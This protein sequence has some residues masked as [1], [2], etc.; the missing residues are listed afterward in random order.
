MAA[1]VPYK[2]GPKLPIHA[3]W[4]VFWKDCL[5]DDVLAREILSKERFAERIA[6]VIL[7]RSSGKTDFVELPA[8]RQ[9]QVLKQL[10]SMPR[11]ALLD[12]LG[13]LWLAP[14]VAPELPN[15]EVRERLGIRS[16]DDIKLALRYRDQNPAHV[17]GPLT[18]QTSLASQGTLCLL[19]WFTL[20]ESPLRNRLKLLFPKRAG[21]IDASGERV[22]LVSRFMG[23]AEAREGLGQ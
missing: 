7:Q 9:G 5:P 23:D 18:E 2:S 1:V 10:L 3:D 15:A 17:V 11:E 12:K 4:L 16:R 13:L 20:F 19:A 6:H 14:V 8:T 21:A 22:M